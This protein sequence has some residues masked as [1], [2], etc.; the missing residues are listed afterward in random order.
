MQYENWRRYIER[1]GFDMIW[2]REMNQVVNVP[3]PTRGAARLDPLAALVL[4]GSDPVLRHH[5]TVVAQDG[6]YKHTAT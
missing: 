5:V 2:Q 3:A 6:L 1:M 4:G